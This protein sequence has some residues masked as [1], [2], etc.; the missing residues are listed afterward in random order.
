M[1]Y[2]KAWMSLKFSQLPPRTFDLAA[3]ESQKQVAQRATIAHLRAIIN[4]LALFIPSR[5]A[6]S[7][8]VVQSG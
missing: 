3:L 7:F 1:T 8:S 2:I 4:L 5:A 6:N